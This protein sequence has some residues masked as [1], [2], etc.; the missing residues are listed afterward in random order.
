MLKSKRS[1]WQI[2]RR[3]QRPRPQPGKVL[4]LLKTTPEQGVWSW[5][6]PV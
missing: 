6:Q 2:R 5:L 1:K 4:G 3:G